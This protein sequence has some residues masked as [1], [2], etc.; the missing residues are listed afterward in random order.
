MNEPQKTIKSETG[1]DE[2][3]APKARTPLF[4]AQAIAHKRRSLYGDVILIANPALWFA[5]TA[6]LLCAGAVIGFAILIPIFGG[7]DIEG[8]TFW[9]WLTQ[10]E[11]ASQDGQVLQGGR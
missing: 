3:G 11:Q 1:P 4:R 7:P 9:Q 8:L 10:G 6:L 5:T 2:N